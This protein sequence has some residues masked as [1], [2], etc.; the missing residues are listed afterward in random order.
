[1]ASSRQVSELAGPAGR[2]A[3]IGPPGQLGSARPSR[4][5]RSDGHGGLSARVPV[6]PRTWIADP[7]RFRGGSVVATDAAGLRRK[8]AIRQ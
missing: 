3:V 1:M 8:Q 4:C 7:W 2:A 6:T 5:A